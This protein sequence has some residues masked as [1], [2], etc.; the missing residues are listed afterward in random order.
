MKKQGIWVNRFVF[1]ILFVFVMAFMGYHVVSAMSNPVGTVNAVLYTVETVTSLDGWFVRDEAVV[2]A[3]DGIWE[4]K[5]VTGQRMGKLDTLALTYQNAAA[6]RDD[7]ASRALAVR[8]EQLK[9]VSRGASD[10]VNVSELDGQILDAVVNLASVGDTGAMDSLDDRSVTLKTLMYKRSYTYEDGQD[11]GAL[12]DDLTAQLEQSR[13]Q[14]GDAVGSVEAPVSGTFCEQTDGYEQLLTPDVLDGLTAGDF[15][16]ITRQRPSAPS[17]CLG[18]LA[19][20][21]NWYYAAVISEA[22]AKGLAVGDMLSLRL[23]ASMT[24]SARVNRLAVDADGRRLLVLEGSDNLSALVSLRHAPADV[25]WSSSTG[26]RIPRESVRLDGDGKPGVYCL[27][28]NQ[29]KFKPVT[30]LL[31]RDNYYL[32]Y[33]DPANSGGLLPGDEVVIRAKDLFDGK[34]IQ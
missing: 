14:T 21:F 7:T 24:L 29:V 3:P 15:L 34:I 26:L 1:L 8:I 23:D 25:I 2:P 9:A 5:A 10:L 4:L 32:V 33:Y 31:E 17:D 12:I 30:I 27:Q 28:Y 11:I 18:K 13:A 22:D 19:Q 20:G 6:L 16:N